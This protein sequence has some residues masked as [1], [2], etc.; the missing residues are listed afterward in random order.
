MSMTAS[1]GI[2]TQF[3]H[4]VPVTDAVMLVEMLFYMTSTVILQWKD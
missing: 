2:D 3:W 1:Y 4:S